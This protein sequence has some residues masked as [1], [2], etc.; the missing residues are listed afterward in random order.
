MQKIKVREQEFRT[1]RIR[2]LYAARKASS[3]EEMCL[4]M[5]K[6]ESQSEYVWDDLLKYLPGGEDLIE[7]NENFKLM[8]ESFL[9]D[10]ESF[11]NAR[12]AYIASFIKLMDNGFIFSPSKSNL[13]A[14]VGINEKEF[15]EELKTHILSPDAKVIFER[16]KEQKLLEEAEKSEKVEKKVEKESISAEGFELDDD[17]DEDEDEDRDED[18]YFLDRKEGVIAM[19]EEDP[20]LIAE[21]EEIVNY[22]RLKA[23]ACTVMYS[24]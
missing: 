2:L 9:E 14:M 15:E 19:F 18:E 6:D 23:G 8:Q 3:I 10:D 20:E 11:K 22:L 24:E 12:G 17:E 5:G 1:K 13:F 4:I 16:N 7:K 21:R